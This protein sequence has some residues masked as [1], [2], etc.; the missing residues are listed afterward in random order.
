MNELEGVVAMLG[1]MEGE[2]E[3]VRDSE[4]LSAPKPKETDG[5]GDGVGVRVLV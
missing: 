4:L 3:G 1:D 2:L 5:V